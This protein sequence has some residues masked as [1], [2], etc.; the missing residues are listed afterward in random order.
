LQHKQ[1]LLFCLAMCWPVSC[2]HQHLLA[3]PNID[4]GL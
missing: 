2:S 1:C 3:L 4:L